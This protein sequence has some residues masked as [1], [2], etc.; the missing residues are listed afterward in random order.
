MPLFRS[1]SPQN[2]DPPLQEAPP[3]QQNSRSFFSRDSRNQQPQQPPSPTHTT[4]STRTASTRSSGGFFSRR[5]SMSPSPARYDDIKNEPSIV[6]A[7]QKVNDAEAA[8]SEADRALN[9]AR[10]SV[11]EAQDHVR[12]LEQE[13]LEEARRAK[14]KQAEAKNVSKRSRNLGRFG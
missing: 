8:E 10:A 7:R 2:V 4:D 6:A 12:R 5:R 3:Q 14:A 9:M 1:S 11:R 13:A